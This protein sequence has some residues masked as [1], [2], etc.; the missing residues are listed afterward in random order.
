MSARSDAEEEFL[1]AWGLHGVP[2]TDICREYRF[3]PVRR[4][5]FDFAWPSQ[6]VAVEID[7]RGRHQSV[8]GVRR[9]C[10][11]IN[12]AILSGWRVLR[13][14]ATDKRQA[15]EWVEMA[16]DLLCACQEKDE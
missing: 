7:G 12:T 9:D 3:H 15:Q 14:P 13:F 5:R 16:V 11:K 6:R 10:E 4:W 1:V 8:A 2:G